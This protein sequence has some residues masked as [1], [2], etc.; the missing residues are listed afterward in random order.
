M[1]LFLSVFLLVSVSSVSL[2]DA[3]KF[4]TQT[5]T[6]F[7]LRYEKGIS[8]H[9]ARK[10]GEM[11]EAA[12]GDYQKIFSTTF[13]GTM[14]VMMYSSVARFRTASQSRAF[15]DADYR[16]GKLYV[17]VP[18]RLRQ[19][20]DMELAAKRIVA[21]A[22]MDR[23]SACPAWLVEAYALY[24]GQ[25]LT[26]FGQP[27]RLTVAGLSDLGED[28]SVAENKEDVRE[29]YAKLASTIQFLV[30]RFT[31][32]RVEEAI[33]KFKGGGTVDMV[34]PTV[35]KEGMRDIEKEWV[36]ALRNPIKG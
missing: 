30:D 26:K 10:I 33:V 18:S 13:P 6:N 15:L 35:F 17:A 4:Q 3:K 22:F 2:S 20:E 27:V 14:D 25:C 24:A 29:L 7:R 21:R 31:R 36:K 1:K 28:Y 23:I 16:A 12:Y 19:S 32:E 9:D 8:L 11:L 5:T 34:F